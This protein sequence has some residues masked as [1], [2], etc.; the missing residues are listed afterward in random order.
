VLA[1]HRWWEGMKTSS[2]R[3]LSLRE[4]LN[5]VKQRYGYVHPKWAQRLAALEVDSSDG[6]VNLSQG[7]NAA[8]ARRA[9]EI[10]CLVNTDAATLERLQS[11]GATPGMSETLAALKAAG[12]DTMPRFLDA[13]KLAFA[14]PLP[15]YVFPEDAQQPSAA[16]QLALC[17]LTT[18]PGKSGGDAAEDYVVYAAEPT[19]RVAQRLSD[20]QRAQRALADYLDA[21]PVEHGRTCVVVANGPSLSKSIDDSLLAQDL[22]ISNFAYKDDRLLKHAKFFTIVNHTLAA[23]VQADWMRLGHLHKFFPFWLGRYVPQLPN[24]WYL[25]ST[26]VPEFQADA[27]RGLSWRSTVSYFNLQ[28]AYSLG[29]RRILLVGFDN[30][31]VQPPSVREGDEIVQVQDDA[32]HFLKN[33]FKGKTWQAADTGNMTDSYCEALAFSMA[34]G[35]EIINCTVGGHLHVFPRAH[36]PQVLARPGLEPSAPGKEWKPL[37]PG[38]ISLLASQPELATSFSQEG[39]INYAQL[40][41]TARAHLLQCAQDT[42]RRVNWPHGLAL[43]PD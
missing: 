40:P 15:R 5:L 25:N 13:Q 28:L 24:T 19:Y 4:S 41:P 36:F 16:R 38:E 11:T 26:V 21:C 22:I 33:Y 14:D 37:T 27:R 42:G 30:N 17:R 18:T 20:F 12:A 10:L 6:I 8:V 35:V 23:Q 3:D 1:A 43:R 31:Y 2:R 34:N 7:D 29:Y 32:N 9:A 39:P